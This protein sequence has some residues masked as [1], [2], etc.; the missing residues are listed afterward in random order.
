MTTVNCLPLEFK[1]RSSL[2]DKVIFQRLFV[3]KKKASCKDIN[4]SKRK[5]EKSKKSKLEWR[6]WEFK[7]T[8]KNK[9]KSTDCMSTF[10]CEELFQE[11][12]YDDLQPC[13]L[14]YN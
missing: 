9:K 13:K 10:E 7:I 5:M 4:G 14:L 8:R 2:K 12:K 6:R 11:K 3:R 1:K